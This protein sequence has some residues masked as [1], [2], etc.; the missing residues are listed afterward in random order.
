MRLVVIRHA[1]AGEAASDVERPLTERGRRDAAAIGDWLRDTDVAPDRVVVSPAVRAQQTW[2]TAAG[3]LSAAP[4][5]VVDDR[6]YANDVE[7][8][9]DI[10]RET[11]PGVRTL[12]LVGHN[13]SFGEFVAD[14][15]DGDGDAQARQDLL[16]GFPTSAVAVFDLAGP[17]TDVRP[18]AGR[19]AAFATPRG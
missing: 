19:L 2:R 10:V 16:A 3:R 8:L 18:R 9:R 5:P 6:V 17:W 1:K 4:E 11:P 14:L 12:V 7:L 15:D 13:P